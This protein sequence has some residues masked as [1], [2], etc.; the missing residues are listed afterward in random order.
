[1]LTL[2]DL[3]VHKLKC[4]VNLPSSV[5]Y[6]T[7]QSSLKLRANTHVNPNPTIEECGGCVVYIDQLLHQSHETRL[8]S[9][10]RP[11]R[12]TSLSPFQKVCP[13]LLSDVRLKKRP[14]RVW[15]S[16]PVYEL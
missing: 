9:R 3:P 8:D 7:V 15:M 5:T 11:Q 12:S 6:P 2:L 14:L 4:Y 10:K 1:M 16:F 13:F